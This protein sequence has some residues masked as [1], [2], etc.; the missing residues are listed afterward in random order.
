MMRTALCVLAAA[1]LLSAAD[2]RDFHQTVPLDP[3]GRFS[4]DTFKGSI[5]ITAWDEPQAEIQARIVADE[6]GWFAVPVDDV[7]IRVDHTP[8]SVHVKTDYRRNKFIE[9]D[10]PSVEYT[11]RVPRKAALSI[12]D[13]KSESDIAGVEGAIEFETYKGTARLDGL[14][15][16]LRLNTYKG[17][18]RAV[19]AQ[20][21]GP[22][23]VDTFKGSVE[24][25]I[26]RS[27]AFDL[28]SRM[29][30]RAGLDSDFPRTIRSTRDREYHGSVNGG[31]P[32]LRVSSFK[33]TIRLR[34]GN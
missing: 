11:I 2:V 14:R 30:R 31:G 25:S 7:E 20:F 8:G 19:F 22:S 4:L 34:A 10:L 28:D 32:E 1:T 3:T 15:S 5:H 18:V 29:D 23:R 6:T 16:G 33:G 12:K 26:P 27:A 24:L 17:D 13:Y 9:G 21:A